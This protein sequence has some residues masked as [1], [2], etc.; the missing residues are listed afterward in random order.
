MP[1]INSWEEFTKAAQLLYIEDP[2][3]CR[4]V[5]KYRH[6]DGKLVC[7]ITDNSVCL[8]Y[9]AQHSQD[10]KKVEKFTTQLMRNMASKDK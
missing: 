9:V 3:K 8:M 5:L 10:V 6:N 1:Y 7:K 4:Y 2:L